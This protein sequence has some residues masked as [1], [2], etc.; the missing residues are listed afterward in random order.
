MQVRRFD[1]LEEL[2]A[3]EE[4]AIVNCTGIGAR[5]LVGDAGMIPIRGQLALVERQPGVNVAYNLPAGYCFP[6]DDAVLLGGT[7]QRGNWSREPDPATT[8]R[9]LAAHRGIV[10]RRCFT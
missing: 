3:V 8:T 2:A 7:W 1:S 5:A 10:A 6:R 9:I 4:P